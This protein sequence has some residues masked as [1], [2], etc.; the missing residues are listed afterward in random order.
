MLRLE[1]NACGP[2]T[3]GLVSRLD[4]G[5]VAAGGRPGGPLKGATSLHSTRPVYS[6]SL[7]GVGWNMQQQ[8]STGWRLL[9]GN[10]YLL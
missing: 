4:M 2:F 9:S 5:N 1:S 3:T 8:I 7:A 10:D 6:M